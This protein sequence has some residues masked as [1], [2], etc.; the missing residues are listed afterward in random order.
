MRAEN[1]QGGTKQSL[2]AIVSGRAEFGSNL[3]SSR[4][5][6]QGSVRSPY[7]SGSV[8]LSTSS[9]DHFRALWARNSPIICRG[10]VRAVEQIHNSI[11]I[12]SGQIGVFR[13][14]QYKEKWVLKGKGAKATQL[15]R[16]V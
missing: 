9:Q 1:V 10:N 16:V 6:S 11:V 15:H 5:L 7:V 14:T 13:H 3:T 8:V 2:V 4:L 12:S